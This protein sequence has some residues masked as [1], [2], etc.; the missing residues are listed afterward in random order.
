VALTVSNDFIDCFF[1][2]QA[3]G[4]RGAIGRRVMGTPHI[5]RVVRVHF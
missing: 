2:V 5:P 3:A 4:G 1:Q